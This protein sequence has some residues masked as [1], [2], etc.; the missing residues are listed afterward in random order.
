V[1]SSLP[2]ALKDEE[3]KVE[4][5]RLCS[6]KSVSTNHMPTVSEGTYDSSSE[7]R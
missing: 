2:A 1:L 5:G 4:E 6:T 7:A 3:A